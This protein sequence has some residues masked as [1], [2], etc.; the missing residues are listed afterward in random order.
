MAVVDGNLGA[1][2]FQGA[3]LILPEDVEDSAAFHSHSPSRIFD[4]FGGPAAWPSAGYLEI[5]RVDGSG[6]LTGFMLDKED[7][8][9]KGWRSVPIRQAL[10][11]AAG[12]MVSPSSPEGLLFR[13]YHVMQWRRESAYCGSCGSLNR[14]SPTEHLARQCPVC[15]R[16]EFPRISPAVIVLITNDKDQVLLAHNANFVDRV[17]S[18]I[19]GFVEAGENLES[20]ILREIKE[21]VNIDVDRIQ[22]AASQPW[23]FPNSLMLGFTAHYV[24]GELKSDGKEILDAQWFSRDTLPNLPGN[25]SVAR[26]LI[27]RWLGA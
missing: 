18:L 8:L 19:A 6:T 20:T 15:G 13:A 10:A 22:Y 25:G 3:N 1:Y 9:P 17:Y 23:P 12:S 16:M 5:P 21:E 7:T 27:N 14:D 11:V 2:I 24:S 26:L 4:A